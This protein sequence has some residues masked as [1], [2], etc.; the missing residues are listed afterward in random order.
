V[1]DRRLDACHAASAGVLRIERPA[2][3]LRKMRQRWGRC[4]RAGNVL[5]NL[6][7]VKAPLALRGPMAYVFAQRYLRLQKPK[8]AAE[9]FRAARD[10]AAAGSRL[11]RLG[12]LACGARGFMGSA[13]AEF[14]FSNEGRVAG[15]S[16]LPRPLQGGGRVAFPHGDRWRKPRPPGSVL[17]GPGYSCT[18]LAYSSLPVKPTVLREQAQI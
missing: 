7:L 11:R 9:F 16:R 12:Q 3:Q 13:V 2:F 17:T 4:T 18:P 1:F 15:F 5:L 6:D 10:A 8:E 14:E